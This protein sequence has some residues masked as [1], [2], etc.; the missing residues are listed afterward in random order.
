MSITECLRLNLQQIK[1]RSNR[2]KIEIKRQMKEKKICTK[3]CEKNYS[4]IC[5]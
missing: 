3:E 2:E 1:E 5:C 4:G